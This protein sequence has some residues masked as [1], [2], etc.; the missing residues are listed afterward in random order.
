MFINYQKHAQKQRVWASLLLLFLLLLPFH[1]RGDISGKIAGRV[2]DDA[3]KSLP[4]VNVMLVGTQRGAASSEDGN[5]FLLSIPPG[6]YSVSA[7]MMGYQ[8]VVA[9]NVLVQSGRTT[10][11][12]FTL[13]EQ[14]LD[15]GAEVIVTAERP[16]IEVDRTS[17]EFIVNSREIER[18]PIIG[19][20]SGLMRYMPGVGL[21]GSNQM[22]VRYSDNVDLNMYYDG[23]PLDSYRDINIF[24]VEE[25]S[26]T[27]GG[28][29]AEYGNAQGGVINIVTK[30]GDDK[31]HGTIE[32]G[33]NPPQQSH[34]GANYW[35]NAYHLDADGNSRLLWDNPVWVNEI[36]S[37]TGRKVHEK[38]DYDDIWEQSIKIGLSG[39]IY[40]KSLTFSLGTQ[41]SQG[42]GGA[43]GVTRYSLPYTQNNW[44]ITWKPSPNLTIR[45]GGF[46]NW[47]K[48]YNSGGNTGSGVGFT[49]GGLG[50][51]DIEGA[52]RGMRIGNSGQYTDDRNIFLPLDYSA[53]GTHS[54]QEYLAYINFVHM[55]TPG[56]YYDIKIYQQESTLDN[57]N[58]PDSVISTA[59]T[60]ASGW[61]YLSGTQG[62][63]YTNANTIRT[64]IK[65][66]FSSQITKHHLVKL[67]VDYQHYNVWQT[68]VYNN[69]STVRQLSRICK[70]FKT[71]EGITPDKLAVY[72]SD[73]MEFGGLVVNLGGRYDYYA[74]GSK[75]PVTYALS[76]LGRIYNSFTRFRQLPADL[77]Y[78]PEPLQAF[79][80]RLGLSHPISDKATIHFFYGHVYQLPSFWDMYQDQWLASNAKNE[81][82][83]INKNGVIDETEVYNRLNDKSNRLSYGNPTMD[84]E[85]TT[86]FEMGVDWNFFQ[87][88]IL[89]AA[90]YYKSAQNQVKGGSVH[91]FWDPNRTAT[92]PYINIRNNTQYEDAKGFEFLLKKR[93]SQ[94]FSFQVSYNV[95]WAT[96]GWSGE[97]VRTYVPDGN[98]IKKYYFE[99]YISDSNGDG[100]VNELDSG[101]EIS[102]PLS[103]AV[104]AT[105]VADAEA[106]LQELRAQGANLKQVNGVEGL[107][108]VSTHYSSVGHPR[109]NIERRSTLGILLYLDLPDNF[110]PTIAGFKPLANI[111]ANL[112]YRYQDGLPYQYASIDGMARWRSAPPNTTTD[113]RLEKS[114]RYGGVLN[115]FF[116]TVSNL[117][118]QKE[119][120]NSSGFDSIVSLRDYVSY[121]LEGYSP[122]YDSEFD[123]RGL[124]DGGIYLASPRRI[125]FG[126]RVNF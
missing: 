83:D 74:W 66:D 1:V 76:K 86:S 119:I 105:R 6:M 31:F 49:T 84:F 97:R 60:D 48:G 13:K 58:V 24:S 85:K 47:S 30:D 125:S 117:F 112:S 82:M 23:I 93:F 106:Y 19:S 118:D 35:N 38:I 12:D 120:N 65:F 123:Y 102:Q 57:Q 69:A 116:L 90:T 87:D 62:I 2:V 64:G 51:Q 54:N 40:F 124:T 100:K 11:L 15:L 122:L 77:W 37:L 73:K 72:L 80:P 107:Y 21:D 89:T 32:Y 8:K 79:S 104:L 103:E 10:I 109:D 33:L 27:T 91:Q 41:F 34:W 50:S 36:D 94:V 67:G 43:F 46:Y 3:G 99:K 5:Y 70:D 20:V 113:L 7:S 121:G 16:V 110:G 88:Y 108:Y 53:G 4:G 98:F 26:I 29:G 28:V 95:G 71:G 115:T 55:L 68:S 17:T 22:V 18:S 78:N 61:Y 14:V 92:A 52:I 45:T 101:E 126:V 9:T 25:A 114:F 42:S 75:F 56:M 81:D 63:N 96:D 59:R 44:K 39:P 111:H